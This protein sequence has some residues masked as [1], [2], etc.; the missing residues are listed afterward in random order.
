VQIDYDARLGER[1]FYRLLLHG[2]RRAIGR[3]PLS[4]TALASWCAGDRWLAQLPVDEIV[5]ALFRMGISEPYRR[6]ASSPSASAAECRRAVGISLDEPL[7]VRASGRRV[8]VFS[9]TAWNAASVASARAHVH[10]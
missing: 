7:D 4:M 5:P 8:Y 3:I 2:V 6:I 10:P 1:T 9:P